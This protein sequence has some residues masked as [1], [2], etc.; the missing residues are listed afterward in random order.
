MDAD[1]A[2]IVDVVNGSEYEEVQ[3]LGDACMVRCVKMGV[4]RQHQ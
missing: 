3:E 1:L 2:I 4:C